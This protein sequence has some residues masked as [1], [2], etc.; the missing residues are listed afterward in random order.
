MNFLILWLC[1]WK[2]NANWSQDFLENNKITRLSWKY[3]C[4]N[5]L[6]KQYNK[7]QSQFI[8]KDFGLFR[9]NLLCHH[10]ITV[11]D[12]PRKCLLSLR[13]RMSKSVSSQ[14][15]KAFSTSKYWSPISAAMWRGARNSYWSILTMIFPWMFGSAPCCTRSLTTSALPSSTA[16]NRGVCK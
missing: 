5:C 1:F 13:L 16:K 12:H 14:S 11:N 10:Q 2:K 4:L 15:I 7:T 8:C 6:T 9:S 3:W